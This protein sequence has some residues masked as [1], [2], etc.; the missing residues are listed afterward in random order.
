M[1]GLKLYA[2]CLGALI[3]TAGGVQSASAAKVVLKNELETDIMAVYCVNDE[4]KTS[5]VTGEIEEGGSVSVNP[6]KLPEYECSR[7]AILVS[8]DEGVQ[9]YQDAEPGGAT[10]IVFTMETA[11][12]DDDEYPVVLIES[13]DETYRTPAGMPL[14]LLAQ[15]LQFGL[16]KQTWTAAATPHIDP[17]ETTDFVVAFAGQSWEL[18]EELVFE[19]LVP[20]RELLKGFQI[21]TSFDNETVMA[22]F[23]GMQEMGAAPVLYIY[24]GSQEVLDE[25][26]SA[27]ERWEALEELLANTDSDGGEVKIVFSNDDIL[28]GLS[29][30]LDISEAVLSIERKDDAAF[31]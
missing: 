27:D 19:E 11:G 8:E 18:Y 13:G 31:G 12:P 25:S 20:G 28:F 17:L 22:L 15:A 16:D 10:E 7:L 21:E 3:A 14:G 2:L 29:L 23:E 1:R 4:G 9:F 5:Q 6:A 24:N 26:K 30:D